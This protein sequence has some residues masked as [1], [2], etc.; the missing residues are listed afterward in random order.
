[1]STPNFCSSRMSV[2]AVT[3]TRA[4]RRS[5]APDAAGMITI[6]ANQ[7]YRRICAAAMGLLPAL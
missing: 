6:N 5:A 7:K 1:M 3:S 2:G 4:V